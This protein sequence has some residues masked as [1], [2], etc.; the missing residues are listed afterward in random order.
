MRFLLK[1][2]AKPVL[3]Y[4]WL[5][6]EELWR[7]K[8]I[9]IRRDKCNDN[10]GDS[11]NDNDNDNNSNNNMMKMMMNIVVAYALRCAAYNLNCIIT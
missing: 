8:R 11:D 9:V 1:I 5:S 6:T 7:S 2:T 10:D 4:Y 3:L